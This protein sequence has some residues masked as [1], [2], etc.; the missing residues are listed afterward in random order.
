[1]NIVFDLDG[2]LFQTHTCI[3]RAVNRLLQESGLEMVETD[4]V[5][6]NIGKR[7]AEF[8][9]SI[10]PS[11]MDA[12]EVYARFSCI[13]REEIS[14]GAQLFD[15]IEEMLLKATFA[16]DTVEEMENYI[17]GKFLGSIGKKVQILHMDDF[18]NPRQV[19]MTGDNETDA[20]YHNAFNYGQVI[21][22]ILEPLQQGREINRKVICLNLDTD[23]YE[24]ERIYKID[25]ETV[26][27]IEGVL[28]FRPPLMEYFDAKIYLDI[29]FEE[30]LRRAT[31]RDVPKYGDAIL[32]KY[33]RKYIPVQR[34]YI[35]EW[36]PRENADILICNEDYRRPVIAGRMKISGHIGSQSGH[37]P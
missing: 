10:L 16:A 20:Y 17:L 3:I 13:E 14:R 11:D 9:R 6:S 32:D 24:N 30:V 21:D 2:T 18:H 15:G 5:M 8:L 36:K 33:V 35:E 4:R 12:D 19:R 28:L 23:K 25:R 7:S 26:L 34:K 27:L 37:L 29:R 31:E 22:E 1:M